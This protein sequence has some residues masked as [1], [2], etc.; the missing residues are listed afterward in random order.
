MHKQPNLEK[1]DF[2]ISVQFPHITLGFSTAKYLPH[3]VLT[4]LT[5]VN[6]TV[7]DRSLKTVS[8]E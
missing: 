2:P 4:D 5:F 6:C 3:V 1:K 7:G 8:G